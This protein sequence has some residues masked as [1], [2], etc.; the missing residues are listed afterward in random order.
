[1]GNSYSRD[2]ITGEYYLETTTGSTNVQGLPTATPSA[3]L[4][5]KDL[6]TDDEYITTI[7]GQVMEQLQF[8]GSGD[9]VVTQTQDKVI[10]YMSGGT[11]TGGGTCLNG[12]G[13]VKANGTAIT[14]DNSAYALS[15]HLHS[16][17]YQPVGSYL[18]SYTETDPI[19]VASPAFG[20]TA[21]CKTDW[22][23]A[24][25]WGNHA[26]AGYTK[27]TGTVTSIATT[28]PIL[29][30]TITGSGTISIQVANTSQ[31]G[32]LT[33]TDWNTFNNKQ[34]AGAYLTGTKADSFNTRTGAITLL[35]ADVEG[36]LTGAISTHTHSYEAPLGNPASN[37]YVLC[38]STAGVRGWIAVGGSGTVTSITAN[39]PLTGGTIT[40]AGSIGLPKASTS[41][42][43]YLSNT[44]WNTFNGKTTCTGTVTTVNNL[45]ITSTGTDITS[46]VANATTTP[47]ITLCIPTASA[48]ARGLLSSTDWTTFNNKQPA[49]SY[50]TSYTETD[51][52]YTASPAASITNACI[53]AWNA[54]A[55]GAEVDTLATVTAR[56][57]T[58]TANISIDGCVNIGANCSFFA[59][60]STGNI[61]F[62][63]VTPTNPVGSGRVVQLVDSA[64][65]SYPMFSIK[66]MSASGGAFFKQQNNLGCSLTFGTYGS[67]N[68]GSIVT[69]VLRANNSLI[70]S[71]GH[72]V[73]N[74]FVTT[75]EI[76]IATNST[77]RMKISSGGT[78]G[79]GTQTPTERLDVNGNINIPATTSG[80]TGIGYIKQNGNRILHTI[81]TNNL[82]IGI[83]AGN[84][85]QTT[86]QQNTTIGTQAGRL[87]DTTS[88][89]TAV[90]YQALYTSATN[91]GENAAFGR[92]SLMY[93]TG[94]YNAGLGNTSLGGNSFSGSYNVGIGTSAGRC[95]TTGNYNTFIGHF[96]GCHANQV[97]TVYNSMALGS[98]TYTTKSY[99]VVIGDDT[100]SETVLRGVINIAPRTAPATA[101]S[102]TINIGDVI[103]DANYIYVATGTNQWKRAALT[104][105]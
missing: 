45:T 96:A 53:T 12:L 103:I 22:S 10:I 89:N 55:G 40:A 80:A 34:P 41:T 67:T 85:A 56:G 14:Y 93:A 17:V 61:G 39:S 46:S 1:M 7:D 65:T 21:Q 32:Y 83:N 30:G 92:Q 69:G 66:A 73:L 35:K 11:G 15:S 95:L 76:T 62:G 86:G 16:G 9:T 102:T 50:L 60:T 90:G 38:S 57:A 52:I 25:G 84:L 2:L 88:Y 13:F 6:I 20:I 26:A 54:A 105:W 43:G 104:T 33:N 68:A 18:T 31:S 49:G 23:T 78:V 74:T 5:G 79:I 48:S 36:V 4:Y 29:G 63:T 59:D 44:D 99:Q 47:T 91:T 19:F 71:Q 82:H 98:R 24:F 64:T 97:T 75:G 87:F 8:I 37:G 77:P 100:V 27:C 70:Y 51:P 58:T 81:G 101:T 94:S 28:S 3:Y 72:M 42:C